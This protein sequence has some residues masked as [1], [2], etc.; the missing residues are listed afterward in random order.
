MAFTTLV[1]FSLFTVFCSRSDERSA[2]A[3]LFSNGWLWAA[4]AL[5]IALQIAVVYVPVLQNAFTTV[6]LA[7][8]DWIRCV[9]V[10]SSVLWVREA[11]KLFI[12]LTGVKAYG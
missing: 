12:R 8:P 7:L 3:D 4:V 1:F 6:D 10:A 5:S 9:I 2:F 11:V